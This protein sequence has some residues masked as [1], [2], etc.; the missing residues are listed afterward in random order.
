MHT[1]NT[2]FTTHLVNLS[3][4]YGFSEYL[5]L[6]FSRVIRRFQFKY[7]A[8]FTI[9]MVVTRIGNSRVDIPGQ[10]ENV[11]SMNCIKITIR[12]KNQ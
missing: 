12:E 2:V 4:I 11:H 9:H 3:S 6:G 5:R 10:S 7:H 8:L 1:Q